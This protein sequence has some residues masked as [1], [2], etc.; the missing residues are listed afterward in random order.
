FQVN[1]ETEISW[2]DL[3]LKFRNLQ[4]DFMS[5][6]LT[7]EAI[8]KIWLPDVD[9]KYT[10]ENQLSNKKRD[11]YLEMIA[12]GTLDHNDPFMNVNFDGSAVNVILRTEYIGS[13]LCDFDVYYFPLDVQTCSITLNI[14]SKYV[15]FANYLSQVSYDGIQ[16]LSSFKVEDVWL[17]TEKSLSN[18]TK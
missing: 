8:K 16:L 15:T 5:N 4:P 13:F 10:V 14:N 6:K 11:L 3:R 18:F 9:Y 2:K 1:F 12:N 17:N 7:T